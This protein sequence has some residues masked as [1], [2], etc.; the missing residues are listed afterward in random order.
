M[1]IKPAAGLKVRDPISRRHLKEAGEEKPESSHWIRRIAAG[2]VVV[3]DP[4]APVLVL[5]PQIPD[6]NA[7]EE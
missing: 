1:Y 7:G 6:S 5:D 3:C 4:P 2:D